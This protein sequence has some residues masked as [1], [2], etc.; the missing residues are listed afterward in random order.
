MKKKVQLYKNERK[1]GYFYVIPVERNS[2]SYF[3]VNHNEVEGLRE[4]SISIDE[5]EAI[6]YL[7]Y[8]LLKYFDDELIENKIKMGNKSYKDKTNFEW[9][10]KDNFYT[11]DT[12]RLMRDNIIEVV[13][14]LQNDYDNFDLDEYK[15]ITFEKV[16]EDEFKNNKEEI[17]SFYDKLCDYFDSL[18]DL[19]DDKYV[20]SF[21][22]L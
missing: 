19:E 4:Y 12:M 11:I 17:I 18:F 2:V 13:G 9:N 20:I 1:D 8:F 10:G 21:S 7:Y 6:A 3:A 16:S 22:I 15:K 5:E 14:L